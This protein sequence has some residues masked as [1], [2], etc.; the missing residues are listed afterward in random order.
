MSNQ[1]IQGAVPS[2]SV[3][4][5][6]SRPQQLGNLALLPTEILLQIT[7]EPGKDGGSMSYRDLK[8]LAVSCSRLFHFV[9]PM[10]Y[11]ADNYA[12]FHSAVA[13]GDLEAI[14]RRTQFGA[15]PRLVR[16]LTDGCSCP[17]ELPHKG[18]RPFDSLLGNV[19][20]GSVPI[21]KSLDVLKWLLD[22]GFEANEQMD[23]PWY[24]ND[25]EDCNHMPELMVTILSQSTEQARTSEIIKMIEMLQSHGFCL[26]YQMNIRK[27]NHLYLHNETDTDLIKKPLDVALRLHC[28]PTFL[29]LMLEE[30]KRRN[31]D[32]KAGGQFTPPE[33]TRWAG[34]SEGNGR[35]WRRQRTG[36][37]TVAWNLFL[38]IF[39]PS[40]R[41]KE[42]DPSKAADSFQEKI[43]LLIDY[44]AVSSHELAALQS[45]LESLKNLAILSERIGGL[46]KE[47]DGKECWQSLCK[48]LRPF[49][50]KR[51]LTV[52]CQRRLSYEDVCAPLH[53]FVFEINW[54]PWKV[55]FEYKL[56]NPKFRAE[57]SFS[58]MQHDSWKLEQDENGVWH[59][60]QWDYVYSHKKSRRDLPRWQLVDFEGFVAAVEKQWLKLNPYFST[61]KSQDLNGKV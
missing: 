14:E 40:T 38:D 1:E 43:Q 20:T 59:D 34:Y 50:T 46:D 19:A 23:Q 10:Y 36:L 33:I 51:D 55:W 45:I 25:N 9:R 29:R 21:G 28:P 13:H 3:Q 6:P 48:A 57:M 47:R 5:T 7:G 39:D 4:M 16:E 60:S 22:E 30:Y 24:R 44:Q 32:V 26:P 56:Q 12:V 27:R 53:R 42:A 15:A 54:N 35:G 31:L 58:W 52:D 41:W 18:H 17:S 8:S 61:S 49:A 37:G 2:T 11:F